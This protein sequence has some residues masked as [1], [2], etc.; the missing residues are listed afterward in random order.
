MIT[1]LNET[2]NH[3]ELLKCWNA[4]PIVAPPLHWRYNMLIDSYLLTNTVTHWKQCSSLIISGPQ[5]CKKGSLYWPWEVALVSI[6]HQNQMVC[7]RKDPFCLTTIVSTSIHCWFSHHP[8]CHHCPQ[9]PQ[10]S[11]SLPRW[12]P[13]RELP[14]GI[15]PVIMVIAINTT[16]LRVLTPWDE[17]M[18]ALYSY[19]Q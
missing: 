10:S 19:K 13:G 18:S 17:T 15:L 1:N 11:L 8:H 7:Q 3:L 2:S 5:H 4:K 14:Y 6:Y 16:S 12:A 9:G